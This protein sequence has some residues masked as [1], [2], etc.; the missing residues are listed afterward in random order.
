MIQLFIEVNLMCTALGKEYGI[1]SLT[2]CLNQGF[3][4]KT[5]S[6]ADKFLALTVTN[7]TNK[8]ASFNVAATDLALAYQLYPATLILSNFYLQNQSCYT[9]LYVFQF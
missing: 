9:F 6:L 4:N 5:M 8:F 2:N 7:T 3:H 1:K